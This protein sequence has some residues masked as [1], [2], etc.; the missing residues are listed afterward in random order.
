MKTILF[1]LDGTLLP[2]QTEKFMETYI[3]ALTGTFLDHVDPDIFRQRLYA[4][5]RKMLANDGG[6]KTNE[7]VFYEAFFDGLD[8]D[9][10]FIVEVFHQFYRTNFRHAKIATGTSPDMIR[11]VDILQ[12]KGYQMVV[13]TN[14]LFPFEAVLERIQWAEL[15]PKRFDLITSF[16]TMHAC[17]PR[18]S[19]FF[20][21]LERLDRTPE[22]VLMVGNDMRDDLAAGH[23][24]ITTYLVTDCVLGDKPVSPP[25]YKGDARSFLEFVERLPEC[26]EN[27]KR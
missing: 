17:K 13:A 27:E 19:F 22:E 14:P 25:D 6:P 16:E 26:Q 3:K 24:G 18:Q 12:E 2:M 11:A 5:T 10:G 21:V 9:Q 7:Q 15:D 20:E 23:V 8:Q 1:D 4:G